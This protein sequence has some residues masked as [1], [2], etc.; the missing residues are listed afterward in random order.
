MFYS[1]CD[2]FALFTDL[3]DR[4]IRSMS[5]LCLNHLV[6]GDQIHSRSI[7]GFRHTSRTLF[8]IIIAITTT[9][10]D[11]HWYTLT[12]SIGNSL[13]FFILPLLIFEGNI[14]IF[15]NNLKFSSEKFLKK[16]FFKKII[17][18]YLGCHVWDVER[19]QKGRW[20]CCRL[21]LH[22]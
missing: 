3:N 16:F 22:L 7:Y 6:Q 18:I 8:I 1:S 11:P 15:K 20:S 2:L 14:F 9:R 13:I 4:K 10:Y 21:P 17:F 19:F 12:W 5:F